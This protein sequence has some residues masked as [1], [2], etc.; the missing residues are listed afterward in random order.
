M[1]APSWWPGWSSEGQQPV[2]A[3]GPLFPQQSSSRSLDQPP[4]AHPPPSGG[5]LSLLK[6]HPAR[7]LARLQPPCGP[8]PACRLASWGFGMSCAHQAPCTGLCSP[9]LTSV[10]RSM[11]MNLNLPAVRSGCRSYNR[12]VSP[13]LMLCGGAP[14]LASALCVP[15]PSTLGGWV[16]R[17]PQGCAAPC[18]GQG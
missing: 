18:C 7:V 16:A 1:A 8:L 5:R 13:N 14:H 6:A 17:P 12:N 3:G 2:L 9:S 10:L 4:A 15:G 11:G